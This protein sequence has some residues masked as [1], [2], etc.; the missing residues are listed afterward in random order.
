MLFV[1]M[2]TLAGRVEE[3]KEI[4]PGLVHVPDVVRDSLA[5][6]PENQNHRP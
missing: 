5:L 3:P 4:W 6:I 1:G 2:W